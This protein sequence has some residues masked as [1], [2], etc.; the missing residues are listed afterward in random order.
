[1]KKQHLVAAVGTLALVAN[2][3]IPGMA[4][5]AAQQGQIIVGCPSYV[6]GD[7]S[8]VRAPANVSFDNVVAGVATNSFDGSAVE[9]SDLVGGNDVGGS[10]VGDTSVA[11]DH[12]IRI[13]DTTSKGV[14]NCGVLG[15]SLTASSANLLNQTTGNPAHLISNTNVYLVDT[16]NAARTLITVPEAPVAKTAVHYARYNTSDVGNPDNV[17]SAYAYNA[18]GKLW[19]TA[20]TFTTLN[21]HLDGAGITVYET[22]G[23]VSGVGQGHDADIYGGINLGIVD[24]I[25]GSTNAGLYQGNITYTLAEKSC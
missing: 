11:N 10:G 16:L 15:W 3:L 9:G 1:M 13:T 6:A 12:L 4:F 19:K 20:A 25:S 18:A 23:C 7:L 5:G 21:G 14:N 22:P 17:S 2:L 24:G 8:L